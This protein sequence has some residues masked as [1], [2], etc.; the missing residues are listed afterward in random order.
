LSELIAKRDRAI[1]QG[2]P[3]LKNLEKKSDIANCNKATEL[4]GLNPLQ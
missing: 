2:F 1:F 3:G 4:A